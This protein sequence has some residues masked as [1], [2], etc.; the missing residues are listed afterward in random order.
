MGY[1]Y[2]RER[3]IRRALIMAAASL[4]GLAVV[5]G[6]YVLMAGSRETAWKV[7]I[8]SFTS[9]AEAWSYNEECCFGP[10]TQM[11]HVL[12]LLSPLT[13]V[14]S[15]TG[16]AVIAAPRKWVPSLT[17]EQRCCGAIC[18]IMAVGFVCMFGFFSGMQ[19]LRFITPGQGASCLLAGIGLAALLATAQ[20]YLAKIEYRGLLAMV[21][22]GFLFSMAR[23]YSVFTKAGSANG[24]PELGAILVRSAL[25]R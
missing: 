17:T 12:F 1:L 23:D 25:G 3:E 14:L 16:I 2:F 11:P 5:C 13:F 18:A 8:L 24:I 10:W 9:N 15:L 21:V 19:V 7:F 20:P 22:V 6:F 4:A